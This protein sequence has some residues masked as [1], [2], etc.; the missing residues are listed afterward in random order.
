VKN[1]HHFLHKIL[2]SVSVTNKDDPGTDNAC[3]D[4]IRDGNIETVEPFLSDDPLLVL[5][6]YIKSLQ[7]EPLAA[8]IP[9]TLAELP[10]RMLFYCFV[11]SCLVYCQSVCL[12]GRPSVCL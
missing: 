4:F 1:L 8:T 10:K 7:T 2:A 5:E 9:L 11:L 12:S 3:A 6:P